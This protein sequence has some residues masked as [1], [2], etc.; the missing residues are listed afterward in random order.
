M[1]A[2]VA[3]V[4]S[5]TRDRSATLQG[6]IRLLR[7]VDGRAE[8]NKMGYANLGTAIG[9]TLFPSVPIVHCGRLIAIL[10]DNEAEIWPETPPA[11]EPQPV[12]APRRKGGGDGTGIAR[13]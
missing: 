8:A 4:S 12:A 2:L 6:L 11:A 5:L 3:L 1:A 13:F 10:A 9:P 7:L